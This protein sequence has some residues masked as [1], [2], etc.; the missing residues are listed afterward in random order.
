MKARSVGVAVAVGFAA[1]VALASLAYACSVQPSILG[2]GPPTAPAGTEVT[3]RGQ[4]VA[5]QGP[6]E[7][8]WNA[9]NGVSLGVVNADARGNFSTIVKVPPTA[10]G[11]Y[12]VIAVS[13]D[14]GV[15]RMAFEVTPTP[16]SVTAGG[17]ALA[18]TAN[19]SPW[20]RPAPVQSSPGSGSSLGLIAG[21]AI[22]GI[23]LVG[24]AGGTA[25]VATR[26]RRVATRF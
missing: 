26:R 23:G 11:V 8:R 3:V 12:S 17:S 2:V 10:P 13:K 4:N 14:T 15:A 7:I 1:A 24:I 5:A 18:R 22:L 19:D 21:S 25:V 9:L 6:V 16:G 20:L